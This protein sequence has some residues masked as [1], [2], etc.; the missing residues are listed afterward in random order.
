M[1]SEEA[2]V[3]AIEHL[4]GKLEISCSIQLSYGAMKQPHHIV[5]T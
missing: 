5:V 2:F 3:D 1:D 4:I